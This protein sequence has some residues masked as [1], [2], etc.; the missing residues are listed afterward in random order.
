[1]DISLSKLQEIVK[2]REAWR[3][4]VHTV[5]KSRTR[6]REGTTACPM[7]FPGDAVGKNLPANAGAARDVGS[8]P[9]QEDPPEKEMAARSSILAWEISWTEEAG[10]L[11]S[12]GS[13]R[14]E[15]DCAAEHTTCP[16]SC[17]LP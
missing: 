3:A 14:V 15:H 6:L 12:M 13:K 16:A 4:A 1:M 2:V 5:T 17:L 11:Q 9:G 10:G 7:G 8:V